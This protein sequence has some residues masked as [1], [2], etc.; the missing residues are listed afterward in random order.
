[1][2][3]LKQQDQSGQGDRDPVVS[4]DH[5]QERDWPAQEQR[6]ICSD[7]RVLHHRGEVVGAENFLDHGST[8]CFSFAVS[9]RANR[10]VPIAAWP[11]ARPLPIMPRNA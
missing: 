8:T 5:E 1:M 10:P 2:P 3:G 4:L 7:E 11:V 6:P 9:S